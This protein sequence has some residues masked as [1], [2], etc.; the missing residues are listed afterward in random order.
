MGFKNMLELKYTYLPPSNLL[1]SIT[2]NKRRSPVDQYK[3]D[4]YVYIVK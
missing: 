4:L 1:C 2:N 3:L